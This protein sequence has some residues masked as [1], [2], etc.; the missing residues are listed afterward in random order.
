MKI[1]PILSILIASVALTA[2]GGGGGAGSEVA[3]VNTTASTATTSMDAY[4]GTWT[5]CIQDSATSSTRMT[6]VFA[7]TTATT[8][9]YNRKEDYYSGIGCVNPPSFSLNFPYTMSFAG[10]KTIGSD[11]VDKTN[12]TF[13]TAGTTSK[14]IVLI[15][16]ATIR[17]SLTYPYSIDADG[18]PTALD[19]I[20]VLTKQ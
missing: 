4:V 14:D 1:T 6:S 11:T 9:S 18:Y 12:L 5:A 2:C 3:A 19:T 17:F 13:I 10:T 15:K 7:K 20:N 16:G 8:L